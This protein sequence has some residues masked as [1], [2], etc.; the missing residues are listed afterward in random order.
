MAAQPQTNPFLSGVWAPMHE[1]LDLL[2]L[3]VTGTIPPA[4]DGRYLRIGPNPIKPDPRFY[5]PFIG[6]GMVHGIAISGGK[7]DWYR[8]RFIRSR[9]VSKLMGVEPA[10]GPRHGG[11]DTVNTSVAVIAGHIYG[12]IEGGSTPVQ[13]RDDL[14]DQAYSDFGGTLAGAFTAHPHRDPQTGETHAITYQWMEPGKAAHVVLDVGGRVITEELLG[15]PHG[16]MIHD[17]AFTGRYVVILD[18]PAAFVPEA[19]KAGSPFPYAWQPDLP[20]RVGLLPRSGGTADIVWCDAPLSYVYHVAN[21]YDRAAGKVVLDVCAFDTMFAETGDR[22]RGLERWI[23]DPDAGAITIRSVD[24]RPQDFPRIDERRFGQQHR[25]VYTLSQPER[26]DDPAPGGS[27]VYAHDMETG[28][29]AAHDF[30]QGCFP[31]EFVFVPKAPGSTEN[32]GWLMGLVID[33]TSETT[34]LVI[35]DARGIDRGPVAAIHIPHRVPPGF[36]GSW[37]PSGPANSDA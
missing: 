1:E 17:C 10:P 31:G 34:D 24:G 32:D 25:Y 13:L 14:S 35:L 3:Q 23:V 8:N 36:H 15:L 20:C 22:S 16:P 2:D 37:V 29:V 19:A 18:M 7:A 9:R 26:P 6:D 4:L 33:S 12:L 27:V 21:A 11:G 30:G 28:A 5:H